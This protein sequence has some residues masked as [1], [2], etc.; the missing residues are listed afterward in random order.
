MAGTHE[1]QEPLGLTWK[2]VESEP[3]IGRRLDNEKLA[4]ALDKTLNFTQAQLD[5]FGA[6]NLR[7]DDYVLSDATSTYFKLA[8]EDKITWDPLA[9]NNTFD[10]TS[11]RYV[12]ETLM[13]DPRVWFIVVSRYAAAECQLPKSAFDGSSHPVAVRL[14]DQM[15]PNLQRLWERVHR[16]EVERLLMNDKFSMEKNPKW[17]AKLFLDASAPKLNKKDDIWP[18][19]KGFSEYDGLTTVA[20]ALATH[21]QL[22]SKLFCPFKVRA[23]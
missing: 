9:E 16:T 17:F 20:A 23:T 8:P 6:T 19:V 22:F 18:Y 11:S 7:S 5:E 2:K 4:N 14:T 15:R 3:I 13:A 12:Y 1:K 21:P 10:S